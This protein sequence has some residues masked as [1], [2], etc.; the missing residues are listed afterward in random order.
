MII[1]LQRAC[2]NAL[3]C[4]KI[5]PAQLHTDGC[6]GGVFTPLPEARGPLR[7]GRAFTFKAAQFARKAGA[8]NRF[9]SLSP[10][11]GRTNSNTIGVQL[12]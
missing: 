9:N 12:L 6:V 5:H 8:L 1:Q 4:D 10:R 7:G 2:A 3:P 11:T